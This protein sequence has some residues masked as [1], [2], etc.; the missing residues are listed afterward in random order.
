MTFVELYCFL[1][2]LEP[3]LR[4]ATDA[5]AVLRASAG[6]YERWIFDEAMIDTVL[7]GAAGPR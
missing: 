7:G 2:Q 1:P 5:A 6:D 4:L 3:D